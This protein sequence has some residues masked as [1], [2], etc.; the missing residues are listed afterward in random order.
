MGVS[1]DE[2]LAMLERLPEVEQRDS[3]GEWVG[4]K[5]RGKGFGYLYEKT[6][7]VGLKA[8]IDEQI[9]LVAERPEV[10][11]PQFT[12][13][14]FGWVIV[15]LPKIEADEL[16][17]LLTEAWCLTAPKSLLDRHAAHLPG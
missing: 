2:L 12:A 13:G 11:E 17:E 6:E 7:T 5:V 15:H 14:R 10:F 4:L 1:V 16:F 8:T 3:G 9:A